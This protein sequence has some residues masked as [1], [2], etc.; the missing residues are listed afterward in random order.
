[1]HASAITWKS[2]DSV[3]HTALRF[4]TG[5]NNRTH[6]CDLYAEVGCSPLSVRSDKF[7]ISFIYRPLLVFDL[8]IL[9]TFSYI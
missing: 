5:D 6:Y 8:I 4:I 2:L 9:L 1:M 7:W 3:Y